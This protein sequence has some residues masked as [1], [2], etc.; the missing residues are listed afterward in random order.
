MKNKLQEAVWIEKY[1]PQTFKDLICP[2]TES[3]KKYMKKPKE[4]P[5][6]IFYS[7]MPGTGK[8]ST[9]Q[10]I[11][12]ELGCDFFKIN[13][14]DDRGIDTIRDLVKGFATSLSFDSD[15]K[16]CIFLDEADGLTR[17][18]QE[19]MKVMM[20]EY[21]ANSFF[22]FSCNDISKIEA[23]IKSRCVVLD[24]SSPDKKLLKD[25][26]SKIAL[27]EKVEISDSELEALI[28]EKYPDIRS[29]ISKLQEMK[30]EDKKYTDLSK[31]EFPKFLQA[32]NK[33]D[34]SYVR[35]KVFSGSFD[36]RGFV[37]FLFFR[38]YANYGKEGNK[39]TIEKLSRLAFL[40]ADIEKS[41]ELKANAEIVFLANITKIMEIL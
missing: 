7:Y 26:L 4:M 32:I 37:R 6:F 20:E 1:R 29:M 2:H 5:S 3:L 19:A 17:L 25:H 24:F 21:S 23:P 13:A 30:I 35:E 10:I 22:I 41:W 31:E 27:A 40:L 15:I 16:R 9:A 8:T 12:K 38:L 39:M 36:M 28:F 14:S 34:I 18:A 11:A 33:K